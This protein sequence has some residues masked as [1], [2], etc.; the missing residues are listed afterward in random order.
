MTN[1]GGVDSNNGTPMMTINSG[2]DYKAGNNSNTGITLVTTKDG[3]SET[4]SVPTNGE[5]DSNTGI[6]SVTIKD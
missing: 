3:D 4:L 1:N 5:D 2:D 6:H